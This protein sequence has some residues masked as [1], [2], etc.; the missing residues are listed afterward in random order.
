MMAYKD[1]ACCLPR[2]LVD[3]IGYIASA[4][5]EDVG[6]AL[7][8]QAEAARVVSFS[9]TVVDVDVPDR[10]PRARVA[11]GPLP[12]GWALVERAGENT[13]FCQVWVRDG[14]LI[15]VEQSWFTDEPPADWPSAD[16]IELRDYGTTY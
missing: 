15:G 2:G 6:R 1:D 3:L 12:V 5:G 4:S 14:F 7:V 8:L 11:N 9:P 16:M 13:G 10:L